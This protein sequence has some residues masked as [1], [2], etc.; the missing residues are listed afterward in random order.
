MYCPGSFFSLPVDVLNIKYCLSF[1]SYLFFTE[2]CEWYYFLSRLTFEKICSYCVSYVARLAV[3]V[4][5][6]L[7]RDLSSRSRYRFRFRFRSRSR[8]K[9]STLFVANF[10]E[11]M[12]IST[13]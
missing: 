11:S 4:P 5:S 7:L 9:K 12:C 3:V 10:P 1:T 6:V 8:F 13:M 2:R